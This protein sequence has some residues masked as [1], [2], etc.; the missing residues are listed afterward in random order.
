LQLKTILLTG[1]GAIFLVLGAIGL[2]LPLWPT[3]PF[4]L[5]SAACF[6][7]TPH[8]KAKVMKISFFKEYIESYEQKAGLSRKTVVKSLAWLW[9]TLL[10]SM[11]LTRE[12][13]IS[14][15]LLIVGIAVTCHILYIAKCRK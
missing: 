10:V 1:L 13:W 8:L 11:F 4:V 2:L 14:L 12:V 9:S 7:S 5:V 6:S 3:T 15:L